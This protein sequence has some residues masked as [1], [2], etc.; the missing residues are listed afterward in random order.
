MLGGSIG[1]ALW[2][3]SL[4]LYTSDDGGLPKCPIVVY[5]KNA[6]GSASQSMTR[7]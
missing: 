3:P 5:S 1:S 6:V 2:K 4:L 7:R